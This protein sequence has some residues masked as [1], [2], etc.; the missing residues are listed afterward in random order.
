MLD[1][2]PTEV[3]QGTGIYMCYCKGT[4]TSFFITDETDPC[5]QYSSDLNGGTLLTNVVSYSIVIV[6][7]ILRTINIM[8]IN[9][10][11][12]HTESEQIKAVMTAV[13]IST[14]FNTAIL[15]LLTNANL[16][17]SFLRFIPINDGQFT[18]LTQ[19]W[20]LDIG[21]SLVMTMLINAFFIYVEFGIAFGM[22]FFFRCL[23]RRTCCWWRES[24]RN[25]TK[26]M[27]IQ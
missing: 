5:Y 7:I 11:G 2:D 19:N 4:V 1:K 6:N 18:D 14:F 20:Y 27:T 13:F 25:K 23:D 22:K 24:A 15:L 8:F 17:D 16:S 21:P 10:I 3:F 12:Y 9:K 26:K